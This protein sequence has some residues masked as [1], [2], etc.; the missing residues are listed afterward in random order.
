MPG[1]WPLAITNLIESPSSGVRLRTRR[2]TNWRHGELVLCSEVVG[3]SPVR[4]V[5]MVLRWAGAAWLETEKHFRKRPAASGL[6]Q[7]HGVSGSV[8]VGGRLA[9]TDPKGKRIAITT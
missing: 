5:A 3:P 6:P 2:V 1:G 7:D 4:R 8:E 9:G